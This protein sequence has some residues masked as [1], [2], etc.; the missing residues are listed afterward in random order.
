M[1]TMPL[2]V[3]IAQNYDGTYCAMVHFPLLRNSV[4][5]GVGASPEAAKEDL[6][7]EIQSLQ[8]DGGLI[9]DTLEVNA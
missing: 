5:S 2:L 9:F 6:K 4:I 3:T 8:T 7:K 1:R